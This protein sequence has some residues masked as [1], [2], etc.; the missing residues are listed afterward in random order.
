MHVMKFSPEGSSNNP[1]LEGK[2]IFSEKTLNSVSLYANHVDV[3]AEIE[4]YGGVEALMV[5]V[6][7][8][9][10]HGVNVATKITLRNDYKKDNLE[11]WFYAYYGFLDFLYLKYK[12]HVNVTQLND[13][14][15]QHVTAMFKDF[16]TS[17][18]LSKNAEKKYKNI[19]EALRQSIATIKLAIDKTPLTVIDVHEL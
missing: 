17:I 19:K 3:V 2:I 6:E 14:E 8:I 18:E 15:V 5:A 4:L 7:T 9:P 12:D 16:I 13:D 1:Y 11:T 10:E